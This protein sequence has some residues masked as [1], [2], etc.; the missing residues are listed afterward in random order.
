M[1]NKK[2]KNVNLPFLATLASIAD[3]LS[4]AALGALLANMYFGDF[5]ITLNLTLYGSFAV[6]LL[7]SI[8]AKRFL[9]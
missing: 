1:K 2:Q 3:N 9:K 7:F 8:K 4:A 6:L 5:S